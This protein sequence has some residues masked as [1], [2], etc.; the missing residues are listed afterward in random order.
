MYRSVNMSSWKTGF[1]VTCPAGRPPAEGNLPKIRLCRQYKHYFRV[2][3]YT[4][5]I[6]TSITIQL[7]TRGISRSSSLFCARR[8]VQLNRPGS[9]ALI[10]LS[11]ARSH[12]MENAAIPPGPLLLDSVYSRCQGRSSGCPIPASSSV[13]HTPAWVLTLGGPN[14]CTRHTP[15]RRRM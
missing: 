5:G 13:A 9:Q 14:Q 6:T 3:G 15:P 1:A 7:R 4:P 2:A 8:D 11:H 12:E 10:E